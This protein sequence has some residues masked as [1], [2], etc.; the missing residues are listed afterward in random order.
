MV[1]PA[2]REEE[3]LGRKRNR[4]KTHSGGDTRINKDNDISKVLLHVYSNT[5]S[6]GN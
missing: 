5:K 4:S 2:D 3:N 6:S 1:K